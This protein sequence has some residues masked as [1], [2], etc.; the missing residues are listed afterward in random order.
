MARKRRITILLH[1]GRVTFRFYFGKIR[2]VFI[3]M[4]FGFLDV[5]MTPKANYLLILDTP[6]YFK[7]YKKIPNHL[8]ITLFLDI[9]KS[10]KPNVSKR[11]APENAEDPFNKFLRILN[12]ESISFKNH[13]MD[14][15]Y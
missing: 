5:S 6:N 10:R 12:M 7:S 8:E 4:I 1:F 2:D 9:L 3:F 13:E 11:R 15:W 14:I